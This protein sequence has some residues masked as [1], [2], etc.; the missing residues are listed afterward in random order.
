MRVIFEPQAWTNLAMMALKGE[1][2]DI[3]DEYGF[4]GLM[5]E[6]VR[7][8]LAPLNF[9]ELRRGQFHRLVTRLMSV[10]L[11]SDGYGESEIREEF[12]A[13]LCKLFPYSSHEPYRW[14]WHCGRIIISDQ[15]PSSPK[16]K[17][18]RPRR[19]AAKVLKGDIPRGRE[20]ELAHKWRNVDVHFHASENSPSFIVVY[21]VPAELE[22]R[23]VVQWLS[24]KGTGDNYIPQTLVHRA[25]V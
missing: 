8:G 19:N 25:E 15:G 22:Q 6:L 12:F 1:M 23:D 21:E 11:E 17:T 10:S 20:P 2:A 5:C 24:E 13:K 16:R 18:N 3:S 14:G 9:S 7:K 4:D